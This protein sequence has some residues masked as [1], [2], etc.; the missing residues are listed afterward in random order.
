MEFA[1]INEDVL[2]QDAARALRYGGIRAISDHGTGSLLTLKIGVQDCPHDCVMS[3]CPGAMRGALAER[4]ASPEGFGAGVLF[5]SG[6]GLE[7]PALVAGL[8]D[9]AVMREP[10]EQRGCHLGVA[11]DGRPL[12]EGEIGGDDDRGT[13]VET[14]DQVEEKQAAGL[15][16]QEIGY[17]ANRAARR[18]YLRSS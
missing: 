1:L 17:A 4:S 15:S 13:F 2:R 18:S 6:S 12:A 10:I 9:V 7:A 14:A 16:E 5:C 3:L 11:K 8:D